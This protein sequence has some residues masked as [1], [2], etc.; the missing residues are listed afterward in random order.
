MN[1]C[2][3][4]GICCRKGGPAL[5]IQDLPLLKEANGLDLTDIVTLRKGELAYDQPEG[6]VVPLREEIL[7]VKGTGGEWV[8]KFLA[9]SSQ[10]CRIYKNRPLECQTLFCGD[11][12][13]LLKIYDKDRLSRKDILPEGH[14]VLEIIE[15]HD[16]KC[17]PEKMAQL[18]A[19]ILKEW[20]DSQEMQ[21]DLRE[22][23]IYDKSIRE[24]VVEKSGLPAESMD[25]FFGRELGRLLS[26]YGII[27]TPN[28]KSFSLRKS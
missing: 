4:C 23:L 7:K 25:F 16:K 2:K 18:A 22:M 24:L 6:A 10:V 11:P 15:E 28:G 27:A 8:C 21:A 17:S 3:Q 1:E 12:D 9:P 13:P 20:D 26:G 14:P 19:D 5:H